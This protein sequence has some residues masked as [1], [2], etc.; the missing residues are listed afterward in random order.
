MKDEASLI[1]AA[2]FAIQMELDGKKY[3]LAAGKESNNNLGKELFSW[4][5]AQEDRHRKRFEN[6]YHS[7]IEKKGWPAEQ[8]LPDRASR[9][10]TVFSESIRDIGSKLNA[11][12]VEVEAVEKAIE[13]EIKSRDFYKKQADAVESEIVKKFLT[14]VSAEEQ[15]HYLALIDYK[16]YMS[17]PVDWFTRTEHHLL[18]GA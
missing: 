16:E 11:T 13:M 3:Y 5:A 2:E 15:G 7:L 17:D 9:P 10:A 4:L 8:L 12:K 14:T 6:I 18:D 1:D